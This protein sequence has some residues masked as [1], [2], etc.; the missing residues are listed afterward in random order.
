[1]AGWSMVMMNRRL[2][3]GIGSTG[4]RLLLSGVVRL[5]STMTV[6][7]SWMAREVMRSDLYDSLAL[8]LVF[9]V[10]YARDYHRLVVK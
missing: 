9:A 2:L 10:G 6:S 3:S 5:V 7:L 1:M 8:S 4:T